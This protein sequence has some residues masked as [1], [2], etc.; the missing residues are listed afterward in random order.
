[1]MLEYRAKLAKLY[2]IRLIDSAGDPILVDSKEF[3]E[4]ES[5]EEFM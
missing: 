4:A 3:D 2:D 5:K 1:M